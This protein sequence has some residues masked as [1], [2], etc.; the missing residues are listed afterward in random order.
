M[1]DIAALQTILGTAH[2]EKE[3][4][5]LQVISRILSDVA[6]WRPAPSEI[7]AEARDDFSMTGRVPIGS[8]FRDDT[9]IKVLGTGDATRLQL[10]LDS[11]LYTKAQVDGIIDMVK[12]R[13]EF[14]YGLTDRW[15]YAA[16]EKYPITHQRVAVLGSGC[17]VY[18]AMCLAYDATP[19]TVE[20]QIRVTDDERLTFLSPNEFSALHDAVDTALSVSSFEHDGLGRYGDPVDPNGDLKAMAGVA[21]ALPQNGLL[22]LTVPMQLDVVLWNV[23]R[24]YGPIRLPLLLQDFT[25]IDV[26]GPPPGLFLS[27]EPLVID[28]DAWRYHFTEIDPHSAPEWVLVLKNNKK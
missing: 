1:V 18:E 21:K 17:P 10:F 2:S 14:H 6:S 19:I 16:F 28:A 5:Y 9:I 27:L 12:H 15:L 25:L 13:L 3:K 8:V 24:H 7:P 11:I 23:N 4:Y 22:Y 26:F 20:Y